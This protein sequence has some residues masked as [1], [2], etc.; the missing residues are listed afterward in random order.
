MSKHKEGVETEEFHKG[1]GISEIIC[2][3][4]KLTS[5]RFESDK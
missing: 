3:P 5:V 1:V 4:C 2:I